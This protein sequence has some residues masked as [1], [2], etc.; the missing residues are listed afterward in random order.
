MLRLIIVLYLCGMT[1]F[2]LFS[3]GKV[4]AF[5][6]LSGSGKS[7]MAKAIA[8]LH[9]S[10]YLVEP[11]EVDWPD[12]VKHTDLYGNF[13]RWMGFRQLWLPQHYEA[14][15]LKKENRTVFLDSFFIKI[16]GFELDEP[17][18]EW[19]FPKD[20]PYY[21]AFHE[22]SKLDIQHLPD[23]DC[24]VLFDIPYDTWLK[25]LST[26]DR[27]WDKT[28]GFI[29]S[30]EQTKEAIARS[31]ERLCLE[32]NIKLVHFQC[33]FGNIRTQAARLRTLLLQEKVIH[34]PS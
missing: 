26:R 11:E 18:M 5:A 20:D 10:E 19:L 23:P 17:G 2:S 28:P 21:P 15:R 12:I 22:I 29:E 27:A 3:E 7:T 34:C 9:S 13:T 14:Q 4:I 25:F 1:P 30:Y 31:V 6:G 16:L 24:I 8:A 32:R 33:Q